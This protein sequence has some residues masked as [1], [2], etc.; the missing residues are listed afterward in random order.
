[1][2]IIYF[3][4]GWAK[5]YNGNIY[6]IPKNG[7]FN[8]NDVGHEIYNFSSNN[9]I[10]YGFVQ[11]KGT[12]HIE[13]LSGTIKDDYIDDVLVVWLA[14]N[15]IKH[16]TR[17]IGWYKNARVYRRMQRLD[18]CIFQS[19][20]FQIDKD[21]NKYNDYFAVSNEAVLIN[22]LNSRNMIIDKIG[23]S[24]VW[25]G[26]TETNK[27][28][29]EFIDNYENKVK[30]SINQIEENTYFLQGYEKE[31]IVKGR[32]NQ[33]YFR[34]KLMNLY[35]GCCVCG[36]QNNDLLVASHIKPWSKSDSVEK[37]NPYNGL[38]LCA[39]HDKLFDKGYISFENDGKIICSSFLN[40]N[41]KKLCN[42]Y[43]KDISLN[44][45]SLPF[46]IYHRNN[47]FKK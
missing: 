37:T 1:M 42:I 20:H 47:I 38:L 35:N 33:G 22:D 36:I 39:L 24:A 41:D 18:Q 40:E 10:Y 7:R 44:E 12:I 2:K 15:P 17:I 45:K 32:I 46:I 26:D 11:L 9:G 13:R 25:Y 21:G 5:F 30:N 19:R 6:D 8:K 31:I 14:T 29:L 4:V 23:Q 43:D 16:G 3:R 28:V 34:N 27:E